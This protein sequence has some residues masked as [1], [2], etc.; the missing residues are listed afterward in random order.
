MLADD[1]TRRGS[2]S[3]DDLGSDIRSFHV[4]RAVRRGAAAVHVLFYLIEHQHP[5]GSA[6]IL[7]L[8]VLHERMDPARHLDRDA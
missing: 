7:I 6:E 8:R 4:Q 3:R 2:R 5:D 1:P